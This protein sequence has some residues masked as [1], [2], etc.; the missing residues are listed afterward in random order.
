MRDLQV[1]QDLTEEFAAKLQVT[2]ETADASTGRESPAA[3][4]LGPSPQES[5]C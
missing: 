4:I 1:L 5:G 2:I 3:C